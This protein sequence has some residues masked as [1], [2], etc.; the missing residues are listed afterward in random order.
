MFARRDVADE[1][2]ERG[3]GLD[4]FRACALYN[5]VAGNVN[6]TGFE[7]GDL[8]I[9]LV[10]RWWGKNVLFWHGEEPRPRNCGW[11]VGGYYDFRVMCR[12]NDSPFVG[13]LI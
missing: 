11:L 10:G 5:E 3:A 6:E 13:R 1:E 12:C 7:R 8:N 4:I 2:R 9:G